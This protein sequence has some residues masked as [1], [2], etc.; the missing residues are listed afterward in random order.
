M[1]FKNQLSIKHLIYGQM[2]SQR[3]M[4]VRNRR[5]IMSR[6]I[7]TI[8]LIGKRGLSYRGTGNSE[9]AYNLFNESI[10]HGNFL[11]LLIFLSKFDPL[12]KNHLKESCEKSE[13][14]K[15]SPIENAGVGIISKGRGNLETFL[16]KTIVNNIIQIISKL[17]KNKISQE[18]SE[19]EFFSL[20]I[21]TTQDI[22]VHDVH[23][24]LFVMS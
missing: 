24:S 20:Q 7:E 22:N 2:T 3:Q 18:I 16:S 12:L 17:I 14:H 21:D 6:I 15:K 23:L 11:E 10:D 19:T 1:L 13:K 9:A 8:K 4:E 5:E